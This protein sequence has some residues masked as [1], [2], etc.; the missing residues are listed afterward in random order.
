MSKANNNINTKVV[1]LD[2]FHVRVRLQSHLKKMHSN[3]S[4]H[5]ETQDHDDEDVEHSLER[6]YNALEDK[7]K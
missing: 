4:E 3:N 2:I 1:T 7:L 6:K 5:E